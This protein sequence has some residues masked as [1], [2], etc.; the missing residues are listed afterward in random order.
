MHQNHKQHV[1]TNILFAIVIILPSSDESATP[2]IARRE[3]SI[4]S[5]LPADGSSIKRNC[6]FASRSFK[7][8][9]FKALGFL[10]FG[11]SRSFPRLEGAEASRG[12]TAT[13]TYNKTSRNKTEVLQ[14]ALKLKSSFTLQHYLFCN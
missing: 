11:F 14:L 5:S 10:G 4:L 7:I 13:L 6:F 9:F 8:T 3:T 2:D 12:L 1:V